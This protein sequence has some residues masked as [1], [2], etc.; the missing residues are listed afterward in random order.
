MKATTK[1]VEKA[2]RARGGVKIASDRNGSHWRMPDGWVFDVR[3]RLNEGQRMLML[4]QLDERYGGRGNPLTAQKTSQSKA[5][6]VDADN[7]RVTDHA[8]DRFHE[9]RIAPAEVLNALTLPERVAW[10][11]RHD[12]WLWVRERIAVAARE[13]HVGG[14][15]ITTILWSTDELWAENPR[16]EKVGQ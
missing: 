14:L 9:M 16:A 10:S 6:R 3:D 11:A 8:R 5:P 15:V 7:L 2:I 12:S 4:G 1:T 13:A